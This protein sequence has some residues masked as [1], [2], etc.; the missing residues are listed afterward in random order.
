MTRCHPDRPDLRHREVMSFGSGLRFAMGSATDRALSLA[1]P[2]TCAVCCR[3]GTRLCRDCRV[4]LE[5]RLRT[6][7]TE[8][9]APGSQAPEP[10]AQLEWCAPF[11]GIT[12]R[13]IERLSQS[14]ERHLSGPLG[15]AIAH[16]WRTAGGGGDVVV[17][18]PA[19]AAR[20]RELGFDDVA[21]LAQVV[22]RRLRLPVIQA[23]GRRVDRDFGASTGD[24]FAVIEP[25]RIQGLSVVLV[26]D[27]VSSGERLA[28]CARELLA[29]GAR[30]VSAVTVARDRLAA[31]GPAA[32]Y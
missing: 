13:A 27:V 8:S 21:L 26:D 11:T 30:A 31:P 23:L 19:P 20:N 12:R 5:H 3:E 10:L 2:S 24:G 16:R 15:E 7:P 9:S 28:A 29:A 25:G 32:A 14:G 1:M 17:P 4:A 18:V 6:G 22:G